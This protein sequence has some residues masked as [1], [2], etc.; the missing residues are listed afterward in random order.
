MNKWLRA[1]IFVLPA[2]VIAAV[3]GYLYF[4]LGLGRQLDNLLRTLIVVGTLVAF[5]APVLALPKN[6]VGAPIAVGI[7]GTMV[8]GLFV[9]TWLFY[10][11]KAQVE[12]DRRHRYRQANAET[13]AR[14]E[15]KVPCANGAT[16]VI[17]RDRNA[18]T[19][20]E[21]LLLFVVPGTD[22]EHY[23]MLA[24]A[25]GEFR[26][27]PRAEHV[28]QWVKRT[29]TTCRNEQFASIDALLAVLQTHYVIERA[30]LAKDFP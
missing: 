9:A 10:G 12:N 11:P 6:W 2:L 1:A 21:R 20:G 13:L 19:N 28:A 17:V 23:D 7:S 30:R 16:A 8:V 27:P 25:D 5:S 3:Y 4:A 26:V 29:R 24:I 22:R 15:T 14:A 18:R